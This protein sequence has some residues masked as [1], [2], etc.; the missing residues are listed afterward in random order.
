MAKKPTITTLTSGFNSTTTLNNN[1]TALR[2]AFDNTLSLDG[3]TPNAMNAAF[4]L[5]SN[6]LLNVGTLN[7]ES[8]RIN[9]VL[10]DPYSVAISPNATAVNYNQGGSGAVNRTV[11]TRLR[12]SV[13]VKDFGAIGDGAT[14]DT[15]AIQAALNS[16]PRGGRLV[17]PPGRYYITSRLTCFTPGAEI[18]GFGSLSSESQFITGAVIYKSGDFDGLVCSGYNIRVANMSFIGQTRTKGSGSGVGHGLVMAGRGC[19]ADRVVA[20][21]NGGCGVLF[22]AENSAGTPD[23]QNSHWS[24]LT[25][26]FTEYNGQ[27]GVKFTSPDS[28]KMN[29]MI[30]FNWTSRHNDLDGYHNDAGSY[31]E[32]ENAD[33]EYN[34]GFGI[35]FTKGSYTTLVNCHTEQNEGGNGSVDAG[36]G[37]RIENTVIQIRFIGGTYSEGGGGSDFEA[38]ISYDPACTQ[39]DRDIRVIGDFYKNKYITGTSSTN[40]LRNMQFQAF[41]YRPV[42]GSVA[43]FSATVTPTAGTELAAAFYAERASPTTIRGKIAVGTNGTDLQKGGV[44]VAS[45]NP[46]PTSNQVG[47]L[48]LVNT[49]GTTAMQQVTIGAADSGGTGFRVLRVP[50]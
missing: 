34:L 4:D 12:D 27:S 40:G 9:G 22:N 28:G 2:N 10:V 48:L 20:R 6:D 35:R 5:N 18:I 15:A 42:T 38:G 31:M 36:D 39:Q 37:C 43:G 26:G 41:N 3:S 49:G 30:V 32:Y 23:T 17:F 24:Q 1:F 13:S 33:A 47:L 7:T 25:N 44:E 11:A 8:L 16:L 50:N 14:D 46:A 19:A 29:Q 21:Y 45:F